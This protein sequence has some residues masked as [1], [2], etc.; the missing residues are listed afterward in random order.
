[1]KP[2]DWTCLALLVG[3]STA[4][5]TPLQRDAAHADADTSPPD[6][7]ET[8]AAF[9][10]ADANFPVTDASVRDASVTLADCEPGTY[11]GKYTCENQSS[12]FP[13]GPLSFEL[14]VNETRVDDTGCVEFCQDLVIKQGTGKLKGTWGELVS[15]DGQL[16]GGLDCQSGK[17]Q[18]RVVDG[19]WGPLGLPAGHFDANLEAAYA[20]GPPAAIMGNWQIKPDETLG[21]P[22]TGTIAL[23]HMGP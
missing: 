4:P 22:C 20:A 21:D 6:A 17:F 12:A 13:E 9:P 7:P 15:F 1:M 19:V 2:L 3:C 14:V 8:D 10:W 16:E 11:T 18:A 5:A 23:V